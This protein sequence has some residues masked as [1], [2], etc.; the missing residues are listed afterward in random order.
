MAKLGWDGTQ[1]NAG[2][3][4]FQSRVSAASSAMSSAMRNALIGGLSAAAIGAAFKNQSEDAV[5]ILRESIN[6]GLSTD[7]FQAM[8]RALE[9]IGLEADD[10]KGF[11]ET[12]TERVQD[13]VTGANMEARTLFEDAFGLT[14]EKLATLDTVEKQFLAI[15]DAIQKSSNNSDTLRAGTILFGGDFFKLN[16]GFRI[17]LD[18]M[19]E[20]QKQAAVTKDT[21]RTLADAELELKDATKELGAAMKESFSLIAPYVKTAAEV[22]RGAIKGIRRSREGGAIDLEE[23]VDG[24]KE[25]VGRRIRMRMLGI[26]P[27]G[28]QNL[29]DVDPGTFDLIGKLNSALN[30]GGGA[31]GSSSS[32]AG[33]RFP[34]SFDSYAQRGLFL[35]QTAFKSEQQRFQRD[36]FARIENVERAVETVSKTVKQEVGG[37]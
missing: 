4:N 3:N 12:M 29:A 24:L 30:S 27:D 7:T 8:E 28:I 10:A 16:A 34:R 37:V 14:P 13:A 2:L 22:A 6:T 20:M 1:A 17:G 5:R 15:G 36:L 33:I 9:R 23:Q 25:R 18:N 32:A 31:S 35:S 26:N 21:L 19:I 11:I